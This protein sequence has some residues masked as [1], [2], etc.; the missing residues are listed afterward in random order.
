[1]RNRYLLVGLVILLLIVLGVA[2]FVFARPKPITYKVRY[3]EN[4]IPRRINPETLT[5]ITL[6]NDPPLDVR[7]FQNFSPD[8]KWIGRWTLLKEW[9]WWELDIE[10]TASGAY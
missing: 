2:L 3:Y 8:G 6:T 10:S 7:N 1:M 9:Y 4:G 5:S